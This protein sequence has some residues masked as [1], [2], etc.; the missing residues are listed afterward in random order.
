MKGKI[1]ARSASVRFEILNRIIHAKRNVQTHVQSTVNRYN[2][3][4]RASIWLKFG[5][6]NGGQNTDNSIKLRVNLIKI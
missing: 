1:L 4:M 5:T 2:L 3:R 6:C